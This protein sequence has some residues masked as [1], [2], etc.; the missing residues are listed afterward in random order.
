MSIQRRKDN[1]GRVLKNGESQRKDGSYM[2]RYADIQGNRKS[3]YAP[4]LNTLRE[5]EDEIQAALNEGI[6]FQGSDITVAELFENFLTLKYNIRESTLRSYRNI[7]SCIKKY[8]FGAVKAAHVKKADAK[9][10]VITLSKDGRK[11]STINIYKN[12]IKSA[13]D[14]ACEDKLIA[15]NPFAFSVSAILKNDSTKKCALTE[16]QVVALL[17]FV[18]NDKTYCRYESEVRILLGTGLRIGELYG[19]TVNDLDFVNKRISVNHQLVWLQDAEKRQFP[20]IRSTKTDAGNRFIPMTDEVESCFKKV[21]SDRASEL[22]SPTIDGYTDFVFLTDS[23][24]RR[25][26]NLDHALQR[27]RRA[28]NRAHP[29]KAPFPPITPHILRHTFCTNMIYRGM[30]VKSVQYLMGHSSI[31]VTLSIYTHA[32]RE[33]VFA[34]FAQAMQKQHDNCVYVGFAV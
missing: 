8:P 19:L 5:K 13:F 1:K 33:N 23:K 24:I 7:L 32:N 26:T 27:M 20:A 21:L 31:N 34:D 12:A 4:D 10:F 15:E 6:L 22:P 16:S 17:D 30:N 18:H 28:Y 3:V 11:A 9:N 14:I 29:D 25:A 2:Y